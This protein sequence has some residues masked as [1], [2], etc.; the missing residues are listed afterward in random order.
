[1]NLVYSFVTGKTIYIDTIRLMAS[2]LPHNPPYDI[3]VFLDD[4][5]DTWWNRRSLRRAGLTPYRLPRRTPWDQWFNRF[6]VFEYPGVEAYDKILYL[7]SDI[8]VNVPLERLF[9]IDFPKDHLCVVHEVDDPT[10]EYWALDELPYTDEEL[11]FLERH[12]LGGFNS[13]TMLLHQNAAMRRHFEDILEFAGNYLSDGKAALTDQ[14]FVN[15]H[16]NRLAAVDYGLTPHV[17]LWP[18]HDEA[19]PDRLIHFLGGPG[20]AKRKYRE[21]REYAKR[22]MGK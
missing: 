20:D 18:E 15:Y 3:V 16:F 8:L 12:G 22:F 17:R 7:D 4:K 19:Y 9:A 21:M 1:M 2:L 13:G 14:P 6:R 5:L 10:A 11:A